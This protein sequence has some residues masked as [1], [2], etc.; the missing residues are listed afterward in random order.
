DGRS[1]YG[2]PRH[3]GIRMGPARPARPHPLER[4]VRRHL[5]RAHRLPRPPRPWG[6]RL[7]PRGGRVRAERR[8]HGRAP[9][10]ARDL[11]ALLVSRL[12]VVGVPVPAG[13]S[14]MRLLPAAIV[15]VL[16]L[17]GPGV[18]DALAQGCA[19]CGSALKDDPTGRAISW[20]VLFL[21]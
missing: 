19:M 2:V 18:G 1:R 4:Y 17:L 15:G 20:S 5:L 14:V 6:G 12:R 8:L 16:A 11:R 13:V 3:P 21:I 10:G 7:A 9:R